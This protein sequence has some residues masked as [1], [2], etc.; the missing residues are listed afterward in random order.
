M[1]PQIGVRV[2]AKAPSKY[3]GTAVVCRA[4]F[5]KENYMWTIRTDIPDTDVVEA[6]NKYRDIQQ[7]Y[8][9]PL[10]FL[11]EEPLGDGRFNAEVLGIRMHDDT[12]DVVVFHL[13]G[14]VE[15]P[16]SS[17]A[18]ITWEVIGYDTIVE[19]GNNFGDNIVEPEVWDEIN[20]HAQLLFGQRIAS[21]FVEEQ[22]DLLA[23]LSSKIV[24]GTE[25]MYLAETKQTISDNNKIP[26][27]IEIITLSDVTE[28]V[29][30]HT[31]IEGVARCI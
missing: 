22:T 25:Y 12:D 19:G 29:N 8:C 13:E 28:D 31:L 7:S 21:G 10:M 1:R 5:L 9:E 18:W 14:H 23:Y 16:D 2:G 30:R 11:A 26:S 27:K 6:V 15:A 20:K 4:V 24:R 3:D 17:E